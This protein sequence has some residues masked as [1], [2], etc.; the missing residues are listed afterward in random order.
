MTNN[1]IIKMNRLGSLKSR[2]RLDISNF[3]FYRI[4]LLKKSN[5]V[6]FD[7][8][9]VDA[10]FVSVAEWVRFSFFASTQT[11]SEL[12]FWLGKSI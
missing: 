9:Q 2:K 11:F 4:C 3:C 10:F 7:E 8:S 12:N 1:A 5:D 6:V